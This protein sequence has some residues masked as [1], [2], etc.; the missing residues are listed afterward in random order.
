M[1]LVLSCLV[2]QDAY[3]VHTTS[4]SH[5]SI[6]NHQSHLHLISTHFQSSHHLV[7][8]LTHHPYPSDTKAQSP[9]PKRKPF[10]LPALLISN[11]SY[12]LLTHDSQHAQRSTIPAPPLL[13][14]SCRAPRYGSLPA[15]HA[16]SE[17]R[18]SCGSCGGATGANTTSHQRHMQA[19]KPDGDQMNE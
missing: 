8:S 4:L 5:H 2:L 1:Y 18:E 11:T 10:F 7:S 9:N 16:K 6:A 14:R 12:F 13:K 17:S 19:S 15:C 3:Y